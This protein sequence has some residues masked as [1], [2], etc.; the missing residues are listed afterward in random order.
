[1]GKRD[2]E[3]KIRASVL[4]AELSDEQIAALNALVETHDLTNGEVLIEQGTRDDRMFLVVRGALEV[5]RHGEDDQGWITLH[6]LGPGEIVGELAFLESLERTASVRATEDTEVV[7]LRRAKLESAIESD[8]LLV[9][10]V[11]RAILRSVHR[12]VSTM[13]AQHAH[14][15]NYVMR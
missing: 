2:S 4:A 8:P 5:C 9:Y 13:N 6:R 15:V 7:S 12:V 3:T 10:R 1:M 11:M 14:L